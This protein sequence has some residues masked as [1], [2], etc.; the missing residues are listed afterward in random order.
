MS[1]VSPARL[2]GVV[3]VLDPDE[4]VLMACGKMLGKA[5]MVVRI[6]ATLDQALAHVAA[7]GIEVVLASVRVPDTDAAAVLAAIRH[8]DPHLPVVFVETWPDFGAGVT[9]EDSESLRATVA[10]AAV[11]YR[12]GR[13]ARTASSLHPIGVIEPRRSPAT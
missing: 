8:R 9:P 11:G 7:G 2:P 1:S 4:V 10:A 3:L 5:G 12:L 6:A 13:R